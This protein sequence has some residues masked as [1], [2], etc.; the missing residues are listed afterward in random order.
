MYFQTSSFRRL[1]R[2]YP[3]SAEFQELLFRSGLSSLER[4]VMFM[5]KRFGHFIAV[6]ET[7]VTLI[8]RNI[9]STQP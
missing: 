5:E 3:S 7:C 1:P 6:D 2:F 8:V 9:G 4:F